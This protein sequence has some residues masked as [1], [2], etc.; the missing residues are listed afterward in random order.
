M[1]THNQRNVTTL[2]LVLPV[3]VDIDA[4]V[5]IGMVDS[6]F[7]SPTYEI[8]KR[9]DEAKTVYKAHL[10]PKFVEDI[11]R[12]LLQE[13]MEQYGHLAKSHPDIAILARSVSQESIHKHDAVAER[14]ATIGELT[15]E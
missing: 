2:K 1:M 13:F 15:V 9:A 7:S 10:N 8:L 5:M 6:V 12:S 4:D 14:R 3:D 11:V